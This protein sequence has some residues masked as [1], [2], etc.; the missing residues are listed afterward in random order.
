VPTRPAQT[1]LPLD[2]HCEIDDGFALCGKN[3]VPRVPHDVFVHLAEVLADAPPLHLR[4]HPWQRCPAC[5]AM[6]EGGPS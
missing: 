5:V 1:R 6:V 4:R 3:A 2:V